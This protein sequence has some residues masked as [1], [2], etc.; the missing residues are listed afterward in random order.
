MHLLLRFPH[1][2]AHIVLLVSAQLML[3][4]FRILFVAEILVQIQYGI[5]NSIAYVLNYYHP[6][7]FLLVVS[8][9]IVGS[10]PDCTTWRIFLLAKALWLPRHS[11][12]FSYNRITTGPLAPVLRRKEP[13]VIVL[14]LFFTLSGKTGHR[15]RTHCC[16]LHHRSKAQMYYP[17]RFQVPWK[18][19]LH[20]NYPSEHR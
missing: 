11:R 3:S 13:V 4:V 17:N 6:F 9:T 7:G 20:G 14:Q 16:H 2:Y 1:V 8:G 19:C 15:D 12:G 10:F 5:Y 18:P